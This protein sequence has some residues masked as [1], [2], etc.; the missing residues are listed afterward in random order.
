MVLLIACV[1]LAGLMLVRA[2]RHQREVAVRLALGAKAGALLRQAILEALVLS[3]SGGALGLILAAVTLRMGKS[4]LP[5]SL[6]RISEIGLNWSVVGFALALGVI[7]GL[8]CG[9]VPAFAALRTNVSA[10]LKE[11]GRSGSAGGGHARLA[12]DTRSG[13]NRHRPGSADGLVPAAAQLRQD[14]IRRSRL[15]AAPRDHRRVWT[16]AKAILETVAGG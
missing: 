16:A 12:L 4:M 13:G 7:T 1:N 11:G 14:A 3:F 5:E 9:L 8:L 15:P 6:P 2:I 10:N